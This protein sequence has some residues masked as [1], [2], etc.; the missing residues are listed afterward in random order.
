MSP[1][2]YSGLKKPWPEQVEDAERTDARIRIPRYADLLPEMEQFRVDVQA[3]RAQYVVERSEFFQSFGSYEEQKPHEL[4]LDAMFSFNQVP[5][6]MRLK[7]SQAMQLTM[8]HSRLASV[9][10]RTVDLRYQQSIFEQAWSE[11]SH[12]LYHSV[13]WRRYGRQIYVL[14]D[15]TYQLL[16]HTEL[17][18]IPFDVISAR[19][20]AFYLV[21]P[22]SAFSFGVVN[23]RTGDIDV[24]P[25]EGVHVGLS[26]VDPD[27]GRSRELAIMVVGRGNDSEDRNIAY[28]SM[29]IGPDA[30][31]S[32][33]RVQPHLYAGD[34]IPGAVDLA[35]RVPRVIL[36]L[37]LYMASE[38]PDIEPVPPPARRL[39]LDRP[40]R[41]RA[42]RREQERDRA[43]NRTRLGYLYIG[44]RVGEEARAAAPQ[45]PGTEKAWTLDH[46]IWVSGHWRLQAYGTKRAFRRPMWI[47]PYVKG[48]DM[49]ES[50]EVKAARL[51]P[52]QPKDPATLADL[53]KATSAA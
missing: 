31:L 37:L 7:K 38:H 15:T 34:S 26:D 30:K 44:R 47:R 51:Q 53:A 22:R 6:I 43:K 46:Q 16:A 9:Q 12:M 40:P 11:Q 24:Q 1:P 10:G 48:P 13:V 8:L 29:G 5:S 41:T 20:P 4:S 35:V 36:G 52:G 21:L 25:V 33:I 42:E 28:V 19:V 23:E 32:D 14:D 39:E 45:E 17:P 2:N 3:G 18:R 49:A 50:L 27:S